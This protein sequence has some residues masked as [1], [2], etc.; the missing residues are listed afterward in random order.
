MK[1]CMK[2]KVAS[3]KVESSVQQVE[4]INRV[5]VGLIERKPALLIKVEP[6]QSN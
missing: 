5:S 6:N 2:S 4:M 3:L 1:Q